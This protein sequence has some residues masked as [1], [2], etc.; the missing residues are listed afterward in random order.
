MRDINIVIVNWKMKND[1]DRC[2]GSLFAD[3][4]DGGLDIIV[5][6]IDNSRNADGVKE[7]LEKYVGV[8]YIDPGGN[9][10]FGKAQNL[11][12]KSAEAKFYLALNF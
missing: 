12:F 6:I 4:K 3:A 2:L 8:K 10:G 7:L 5:H 9:I 11:G 1:I